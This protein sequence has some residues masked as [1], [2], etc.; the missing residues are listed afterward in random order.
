MAGAGPQHLFGSR[1]RT[2]YPAQPPEYIQCARG[3]RGEGGRPDWKPWVH[4]RK[5]T[6]ILGVAERCGKAVIHLANCSGSAKWN[7]WV[8]RERRKPLTDER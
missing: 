1:V 6:F 5:A 7:T 3:Y 4:V 8:V 2:G